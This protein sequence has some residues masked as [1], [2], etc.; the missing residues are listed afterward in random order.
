MSR[1]SVGEILP[2]DE[3]WKPSAPYTNI[4]ITLKMIGM[5]LVRTI[6][7]TSLAGGKEMLRLTGLIQ[8]APHY[9]EGVMIPITP[10][11]ESHAPQI[12]NHLLTLS[13]HDRYLRFGYN[14]TDEQNRAIRQ[15]AEF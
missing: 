5:T 4:G 2:V 10:L 12:S 15:H 7:K 13:Q 9:S 1:E 6:A 8:H 11:N 3:K 14:A